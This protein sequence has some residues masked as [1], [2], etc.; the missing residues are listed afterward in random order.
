MYR[1]GNVVNCYKPSE[2][3]E[4]MNSNQVDYF[5]SLL[6]K[7]RC[8]LLKEVDG[9]KNDLKNND[10]KAADPVDLSSAHADILLDFHARER[11]GDAL[12]KI[13]RALSRIV[14][15]E[16]GYCELTG[17]E[18]GIKRLNAKPTATLCIEAQE[19]LERDQKRGVPAVPVQ[20]RI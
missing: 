13:D 18:I 4:Y 7:K 1:D 10:L 20:G 2:D 14:D 9:F 16:Y 3:E 17:D 15:G 5:R 11:N 6:L 12:E 8:E 19:M